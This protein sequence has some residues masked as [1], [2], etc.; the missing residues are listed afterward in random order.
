MFFTTDK[1]LPSVLWCCWLGGRKGIRPVKNM[2]DGGGR[3]WLVRME[4][5][6]AG[7]SVCLPLLIF[8]CTIKSRSSILAPAHPGGPRERAVKWLWCGGD[9]IFV[10]CTK[11]PSFLIVCLIV[12]KWSCWQT[13]RCCWKHPP[14]S[15]MLHW[16]V[17]ISPLPTLKM[18]QYY[19]N[20]VRGQGLADSILTKW[21]HQD[22]F[23]LSYDKLSLTPFQVQIYGSAK[24]KKFAKKLLSDACR[25]L[26]YL[27]RVDDG[28]NKEDSTEI[29]HHLSHMLSNDVTITI[30]H[31]LRKLYVHLQIFS[32]STAPASV[33]Y[34]YRQDLSN[35]WDARPWR[36][37]LKI[38]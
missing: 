32:T 20:V 2:G 9:E 3:H 35:R 12:R 18:F 7:W 26:Q 14:R 28:F 27:E 33:D 34:Y 36:R 6:S 22:A 31:V 30:S 8:P 5:R 1:Q 38:S 24:E 10:Q 11:P 16:W 17:K 13:N 29:L 25:S 15:A 21:R 23:V 4:W 19:W 37:E